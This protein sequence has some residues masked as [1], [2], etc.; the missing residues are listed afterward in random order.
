MLVTNKV[1]SK[2]QG[3]PSHPWGMPWSPTETDPLDEFGEGLFPHAS[4]ELTGGAVAPTGYHVA[5][6]FWMESNMSVKRLPEEIGGHKVSTDNC[7]G[8]GA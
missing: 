2:N 5:V 8:V 3:E 1:F 4:M 7:P 6:R